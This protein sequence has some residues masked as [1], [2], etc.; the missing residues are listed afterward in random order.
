MFDLVIFS[1]SD[2]RV[3]VKASSN[4]RRWC[5]WRPS[6]TI[7]AAA[8]IWLTNR[9]T[10]CCFWSHG[11]KHRTSMAAA[12]VNRSACCCRKRR[13]QSVTLTA[14]TF[15]RTLSFPAA[16]LRWP[17]VSWFS[18]LCPGVFC[19]CGCCCRCVSQLAAVS[20]VLHNVFALS[21]LQVRFVRNV[22][23]WREMKPGFYHGHVAYLDFSK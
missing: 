10:L 5:V 20:P 1:L 21:W 14:A 22:T 6:T 3:Y 13:K 12:S 4:K 9:W 7:E 8:G 16:G 2:H 19:C 18:P 23:S 15:F 17:R 11:V